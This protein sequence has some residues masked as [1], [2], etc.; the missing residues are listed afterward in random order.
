[1]YFRF[2]CIVLNEIISALHTC[3]A[4]MIFISY[5]FCNVQVSTQSDTHC[6]QLL[7]DF[8]IVFK[9]VLITPRSPWRI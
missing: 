7:I 9:H 1:L 5:I 3:S 4:G 8:D 6:F 2:L